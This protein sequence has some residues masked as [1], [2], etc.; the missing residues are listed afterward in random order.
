MKVSKREEK[1]VRDFLIK[2]KVRDFLIT[3]RVKRP[4]VKP[5]PHTCQT[6]ITILPLPTLCPQ[7]RSPASTPD[8]SGEFLERLPV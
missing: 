8:A 5:H 3:A 1:K 7:P 6:H 4:V 2:L